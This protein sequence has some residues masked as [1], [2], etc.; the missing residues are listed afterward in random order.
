MDN[1]I[2]SFPKPINEPAK[3]VK[4]YRHFAGA[5]NQHPAGESKTNDY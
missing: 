4:G 5:E 3:A 2:F 1:A